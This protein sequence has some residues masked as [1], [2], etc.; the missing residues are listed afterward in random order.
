M[1]T[2]RRPQFLRDQLAC[3]FRQTFTDFRVVISDNDPE[4]SARPVIEE[5]NDPRIRYF[6]NGSNLGMVK[7]FNKSLERADTEFVVMITDDDPVYPD[8]LQDL[9]KIVADYPGFAIYSGCK[10]A[11]G[12][13]GKIEVFDKDNFVFQLLHPQLTKSILWSS[14]LLRKDA[15]MAAGGMA[16]YGSPHLADHALLA[17]CSRQSGGVMVNRMYSEFSSHPANFSK[18]NFDLYYTGCKE[19]YTLM[20]GS[21]PPAAYH[22]GSDNALIRHLEVW[23]IAMAFNLRRFY[24]HGKKDPT[25]F[26]AAAASLSKILTLP[27]MRHLYPRYLA[28]KI[29]FY[30]KYPLYRLTFF[31][32]KGV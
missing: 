29:M 18:T 31:N 32:N 15:A 7:S 20:T 16:D 8:M 27:F 6:H 10:R 21:F 22:K 5:C 26:K 14:C 28:K 4:A 25:G 12:E 1:S 30:I 13:T 23:F 24:A 17:L 3:I 11:H 2:Y 9:F 19:F